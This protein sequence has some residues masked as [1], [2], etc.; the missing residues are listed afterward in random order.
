[1]FG[2][3][4]NETITTEAIMTIFMNKFDDSQLVSEMLSITVKQ[5]QNFLGLHRSPLNCVILATFFIL[6]APLINKLLC[7]ELSASNHLSSCNNERLLFLGR[8]WFFL[9][10]L[11]R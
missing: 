4:V 10:L 1:M 11:E 5:E 3:C 2:R 7:V 6:L 8:Y 9:N